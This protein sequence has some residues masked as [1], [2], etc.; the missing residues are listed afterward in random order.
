MEFFVSCYRIQSDSRHIRRIVYKLD[1]LV[2]SSPRVLG[3]H[4]SAYQQ[5]ILV[6]QLNLNLFTSI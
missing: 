6:F 1:N 4:I 2:D 5:I 3:R